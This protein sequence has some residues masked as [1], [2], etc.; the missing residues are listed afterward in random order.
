MVGVKIWHLVFLQMAAEQPILCGLLNFGLCRH[1]NYRP[2]KS[3]IGFDWLGRIKAA[4]CGEVHAVTTT[5][6]KQDAQLKGHV[7]LWH[8]KTR[9]E[10][11]METTESPLSNWFS[12]LNRVAW[13]DIF[14]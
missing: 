2:E 7:T 14:S 6:L 5:K 9:M 4:C 12:A 13:P 10:K 11:R 8:D 1:G 3:L